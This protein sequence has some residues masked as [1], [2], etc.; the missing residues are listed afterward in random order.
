[1]KQANR[2][3]LTVVFLAAMLEATGTPVDP[4]AQLGADFH[5]DLTN[6]IHVHIIVSIFELL[7]LLVFILWLRRGSRFKRTIRFQR[8]TL[9]T[10]ILVFTGMLVFGVLYGQFR[11]GATLT[12]ALWEV[13]G[14]GMLVLGYLLAGMFVQSDRQANQLTWVLLAAS[15]LL[16][17]D[18][19]IRPTAFGI[20]VS[21]NDLTYDHIDSLV[22][23]YGI[24]LCLAI[25]TYGGTRRQKR[26]TVVALPILI[27]SLLIMQRRAAFPVVGI[28]V[29]VL[30]IFLL[31]LRPRLFWRYVPP[32]AVLMALYLAVFWT[33]TSPIGQPARA[34]SS[35]FTPDP[36]DYSSNLYRDIE[37]ADIITNIK[38][39]TITGIGFGQPYVFYYPLPDLSF[40][41]FWHFETHNAVL[42][43]WMKDGAAGFIVFWWLLGRGAYDGS[44]AVESQREEW[45]LV[46]TLRKRFLRRRH[47]SLTSIYQEAETNQLMYRA[48]GGPSAFEA[49]RR[50][51]RERTVGLNVPTWERSDDRKSKTVRR[52]AT[53]ALLVVAVCTIPMQIVYSYVDLGLISERDMLLFGLML[54]LIAR[55]HQLLELVDAAENK[56]R[57]HH[58]GSAKTAFSEPG[59]RGRHAGIQQPMVSGALATTDV[60]QHAKSV[61]QE[62]KHNAPSRKL[63]G[64]ETDM[65]RKRDEKALPWE[66]TPKP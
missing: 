23:G 53:L 25:I 8:G 54:G 60:S 45:A 32:L 6:V 19:I 31:R 10:P 9:I 44:K 18:N 42:W 58:T 22:I 3:F 61:K 47:G 1:M 11:G 55:G 12:E 21:S 30:V 66:M 39:A 27:T 46:E 49:R 59:A 7:V 48:S 52:S 62:A 63:E 51:P 33:N 15:T 14:F 65:S 40:W 13:R 37:K 28:G 5:S 35:Q 57:R 38:Q 34:I 20:N 26:F 4:L 64:D 29:V 41:P 36:R 17:L 16:A 56:I 43:V 50:R 24:L 2:L